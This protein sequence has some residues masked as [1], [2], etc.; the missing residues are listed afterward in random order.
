PRG[1]GRRGAGPRSTGSPGVRTKVLLFVAGQLAVSAAVGVLAAHAGAPVGSLPRVLALAVAFSAVSRIDMHLE[2][3]RN[4]MTLTLAEAVVVIAFFTVGPVG[5]G[6]AAGL[7]ELLWRA[8]RRMPMERVAFNAA[9]HM[10]AVTVASA[11]FWLVGLGRADDL[12]AWFV[13]LAAAMCFSVLNYVSLAA[14]LAVIEGRSFRKMLLDSAL[15]GFVITMAAAP[16]GLIALDLFHRGSLGPVLL[17]PLV[18]AVVANSRHAAR[19][20]DEHLRFE[21]LY[22]AASR[23]ARLVGFEDAMRAMATESR[24]L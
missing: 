9:N 11:A 16:L 23:T 19:Q 15:S 24:V 13:A 5:A 20:R 22:E 6:V 21:R 8:A 18:V 7:G 10:C 17:V 14:L 2:F 4:Q 12:T 3:R 1:A